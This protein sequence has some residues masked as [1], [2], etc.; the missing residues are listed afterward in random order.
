VSEPNAPLS[1]VGTPRLRLNTL[2]RLR[3]LAIGG[4][5][6][7]LLFVAFVLRFPTPLAEAAMVV[8]A[9]T[10]LNVVLSIRYSSSHRF[11]S[12][13]SALLLG[14]DIAQLGALLYLTGGLQNPFSILFLAPVLI[15]ASTLEPKF[16]VGLGVLAVAIA[17]LLAFFHRP[18][19]WIEGDLLSL[20]ATYI[21]GIW[22]SIL[23]GLAFIG[24]YAWRVAEE[25]RQMERALAATERVLAREQHLTA[26]DGLAAAAAHQLGTP[27]ATIAVV[28]REMQ[29]AVRPD[30]PFYDDI[31]LLTQESARCR[32]ILGKIASL[33]ADS[34]S[35]LGQHRLGELIEE[36]AAPHRN[37]GIDIV[38]ELKGEEPQPHAP[39][40]P[41]LLY[42]IGNI[43]ENATDFAETTVAITAEWG[44]EQVRLVIADD[45]PG[46][47]AD[48]LQRI[49]EPYMTSRPRAREQRRHEGG[50]MGL[51]LFIAKTLLE[52]SGADVTWS[53]G[54]NGGAQVAIV[55]PKRS[56]GA[57]PDILTE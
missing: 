7:A 42:G 41:G 32:E 39:R 57:H 38:V 52:R 3:W 13:T 21:V 17:S 48:M 56:F 35:P 5:S 30:S 28:A 18:L 16:T 54:P 55:W 33:G 4:Q 23:L 50:G 37:F 51:G 2:T 34:G 6:V 26:L 8:L 47:S 45:G 40:N 46:F 12:R 36:V 20:P 9:A 25:S 10:M 31:E 27:L 53:N 49:G 1:S 11:G 24:V 29:R 14:F 15:S 19:P 43:V 22:I 44:D